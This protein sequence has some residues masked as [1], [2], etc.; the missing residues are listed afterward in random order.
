MSST[1]RAF[2]LT[3]PQ[4]LEA[5]PQHGYTELDLLERLHNAEPIEGYCIDCDHEWDA[6]ATDRAIV[7]KE[8]S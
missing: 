4:C 1:Q 7:E 5:R 8:L 6:S 2:S 3:C